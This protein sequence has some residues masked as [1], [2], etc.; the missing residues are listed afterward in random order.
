MEGSGALLIAL[1]TA[2]SA[3]LSNA[4]EA[5]L[6]PAIHTYEL[7]A[8][9]YRLASPEFLG[10]SGPGAARTSRHLA[11]AFE[12]LGLKPA[13]NDSYYQPI[14]SLLTEG[15][16]KASIIGRNV[17][18]ILPG[19]D[20][21]LK[22]EWI[23]LSAHYDHLGKRGDI[24]Y[25]GADDNAT[26]VAMLLEV[27]E[28][29]ALSKQK[30]RRT[31]A[32]ISFD[33]EE[34]GLRGSTYFAAHSPLPFRKLKAFLTAD[35]LGRSMANV[36]DEY[37]FVLGSERSTH[38]RQLVE[39][40]K[41][42]KGLT[43]GRLGA[44]LVG[45]RS[46]Y[47]PFRDRDVPFLFFSTGQHPDYHS[48]NDLPERVDYPKLQRGSVY[49]RDLTQ[50]LANDD[51]APAWNDKPLPPDL[52]EIRTVAVLVGRVLKRQ[53]LYPLSEK[54]RQMVQSVANR[55]ATILQHGKVSTSDRTWL[56]WNARLLLVTV[57]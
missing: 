45:T 52:N 43:I 34:T 12:R 40:V 5:E 57:F 47:G 20:P 29:F 21:K 27:A 18:A 51:E 19:S 3:I 44:D 24:L 26:G 48:P 22:D 15:T 6:S 28:Y 49:I 25:P 23:I 36:M 35:M 9:V 32:F 14:P 7:R 37:V 41:P 10:R 54:K 46:D 16:S 33:Q 53:D 55:L 30:P 1:W 39:K 4:A 2:C 13:F 11:A 42:P 50:R 31:I 38:L 8:H 17:G 56:L